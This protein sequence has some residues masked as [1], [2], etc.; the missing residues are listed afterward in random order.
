[1]SDATVTHAGGSITARSLSEY[2]A[3]RAART[4]VHHKVNAESP[5]YTLRDFTLRDGSF[6]LV[7]AGESEADDAYDALCT[8]QVLTL[9]SASR[10]GINMSFIIPEGSAPEITPGAAGETTIA[11]SYQEV[12]P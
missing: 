5:D 10:P 12:T 6:V 7:F 4:R 11:I 8:P 2:T 3:R 1:M 9:T